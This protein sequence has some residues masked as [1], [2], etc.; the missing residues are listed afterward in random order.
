MRQSPAVIER[1][2]AGR[3]QKPMVCPTLSITSVLVLKNLSL[4]CRNS[5]HRLKP[6]LPFAGMFL[7]GQLRCVAYMALL[8]SPA[9]AVQAQEA[10]FAERGEQ[11]KGGGWEPSVDKG[12]ATPASRASTFR[13]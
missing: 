2:S 5:S 4:K 1:S 9:V 8:V 7:A 10:H 11:P 13:A 12:L 6:V 3:P